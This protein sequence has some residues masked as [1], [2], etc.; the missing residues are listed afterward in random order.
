MLHTFAV[1]IGELERLNDADHLVDA[2]AH[3]HV[4]HHNDAQVALRVDHEQAAIQSEEQY[5]YKYS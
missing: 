3:R 2:A 5:N 1:L 4:V